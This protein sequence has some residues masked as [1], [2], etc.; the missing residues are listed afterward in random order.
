MIAALP[1]IAEIEQLQEHQCQDL[2]IK[3]K[4]P[5][6]NIHIVAPRLRDLKK[7]TSEN[8]SEVTNNWRLRTNI[9]LSHGIWTETSQ[10]ELSV[11]LA[12][13]PSKE[14]ELCKP[15]KIFFAPKPIRKGI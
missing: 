2:R 1:L 13:K 8:G 12:V 6:Q 10:V 14:L 9:L 4:Y 15:V 7:I 5:D 11:C 3:V